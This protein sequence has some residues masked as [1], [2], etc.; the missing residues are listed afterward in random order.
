[1]EL[2]V[3]TVK[4]AGTAREDG[5]AQAFSPPAGEAGLGS[6]FGVVALTSEQ[7]AASGKKILDK[8]EEEK[9]KFTKKN[10]AELKSLVESLKHF[11]S[12]TQELTFALGILVGRVLYLATR[13]GKVFLKR[14]EKCLLVCKDE[15]ATSGFIQGEDLIIFQT[16][17]FAEIVSEE[18]LSQNL[19]H[20]PPQEIAEAL[21]PQVYQ[22]EDNSLAA[23]L[24]LK[25]ERAEAAE[26]RE[27]EN[28]VVSPKASP[29]LP[30]EQVR[31]TSPKRNFP[32]TLLANIFPPR[33]IYLREEG[34]SRRTLLT[35]AI[36]LVVLLA[37][38]IFFQ[39]NRDRSARENS[40]FSQNLTE[41]GQKYEEGKGLLGLNDA[42]ARKALLEAKQKAQSLQSLAKSQSNDWK[43]AEELLAKIEE[44]LGQA[45]KLYRISDAPIFLDLGLVKQGAEGQKIALY[46]KTLAVLDKNGTAYSISV[47]NKSSQILAGNLKEAKF[48]AIHGDN[49]YVLDAEGIKEISVKE[50]TAKLKISKDGEWGQIAGVVAYAGNLYLLDKGKN[51][52]WKYIRTETGF[53]D[54]KNYLNKD[55]TPDFSRANSLTIDGAVWV[56]SGRNIIKYLSGRPDAFA[57]HGLDQDF[58][59]LRAIYTND[60][61][62]NLY[63]LDSDNKRV[64]VL[65]K[66]GGYVAQY[67]AD[68]LS[69]AGDLAVSESEGKILVL[70]GSK[71]YGIEIK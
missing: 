17:R 24:I 61:N 38:S 20:H 32:F 10:L 47:V 40:Q 23:A 62:K 55:I 53:T 65:D 8:I 14:G 45:Q 39:L 43:K 36:I 12:E 1:M 37:T 54:K 49:V 22:D 52:I 69:N 21:N 29:D 3:Q 13:G 46:E 63:I 71:I 64:V 28:G 5:W 35:V 59:N 16:P 6:L 50:K 67:Q 15:E 7:A 31:E 18:T 44:S 51:Q 30:K 33:R 11:Q 70:A 34:G 48:L 68:F 57:T 58:D 19:N 26:E 56:S 9:G 66:K 60:N 41:A 25:M 4:I 42:L 27:E 2:T